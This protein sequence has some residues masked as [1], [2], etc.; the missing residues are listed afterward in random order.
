[1]SKSKLDENFEIKEGI[2]A[3]DLRP[4][5]SSALFVKLLPRFDA[6]QS[7]HGVKLPDKDRQAYIRLKTVL[8]GT[9]WGIA[10]RMHGFSSVRL[11]L[12]IGSSL[13]DPARRLR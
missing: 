5:H 1:M 10:R 9:G 2:G 7:I 6:K 11:T 13:A 8:R 3:E 12:A 4:A